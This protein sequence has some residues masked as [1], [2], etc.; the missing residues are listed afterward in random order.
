[1]PRPLGCSRIIV[2]HDHRRLQKY[3]DTTGHSRQCLR[4]P[5]KARCR[6][7][8][9]SNFIYGGLLYPLIPML[10]GHVGAIS[11]LLKDEPISFFGHGQP[12]RPVLHHT[13]YRSF[14]LLISRLIAK[15]NSHISKLTS[16][17]HS[18]F[19][20]RGYAPIFRIESTKIPR[21][22]SSRCLSA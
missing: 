11:A 18:P 14:S 17:A 20:N 3:P 13:P 15:N 2:P 12:R 4:A 7:N 19:L 22:F 1:M 8:L 5:Q 6:D 10:V 21:C 9:S 16:T